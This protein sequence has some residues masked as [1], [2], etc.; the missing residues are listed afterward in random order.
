[1]RR[2]AP[3]LRRCL[4]ALGFPLLVLVMMGGCAASAVKDA[5]APK[6]P[7]P[8]QWPGEWVTVKAGCMQFIYGED[9]SRW[10]P[11]A[12]AADHWIT[13]SFSFAETTTAEFGLI[14][15]TGFVSLADS[16]VATVRTG[17]PPGSVIEWAFR[18]LETGELSTVA[19][20]GGLL[21]DVGGALPRALSVDP[22]VD[23]DYF[24]RAV[25]SFDLDQDGLPDQAVSLT[26]DH[27]RGF[28]PV[29]CPR[30]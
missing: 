22:R 9:P 30:D 28:L 29:S 13:V 21:V 26:T 7:I 4:A 18:S 20:A 19:G 6:I 16:G 27:P 23:E 10:A 5:G 12:K 25:L 1:M 14:A 8:P 24:R 17:V 11:G 2:L 15:A 3:V